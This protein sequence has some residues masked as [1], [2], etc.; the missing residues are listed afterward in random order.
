VTILNIFIKNDN[1]FFRVGFSKLMES[2]FPDVLFNMHV[3][4]DFDKEVIVDADIMAL[5]LCRGEE[6]VC[7]P[8]LLNRRVGLLI[9]LVDKRFMR[10]GGALPLCLQDMVF[11][12]QDE[13]INRIM[14][15]IKRIHL[16]MQAPSMDKPDVRCCEC[17]HRKLSPQQ[18]KVAAALHEGLP[19]SDIARKLALCTK[20]VFSHKR[21]IMSKF[22][23]RNDLDLL[24]LL[25]YLQMKDCLDMRVEYNQNNSSCR[26]AA[27]Q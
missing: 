2:L 16:L 19:V 9:G 27:T 24:L 10:P 14:A 11:I 3:I 6:F 23:L 12:Q 22:N 13:Q 15:K 18:K 4:N 26:K 17:R 21:I 8:E 1:Y 20:T 25:K 5:N 7:H